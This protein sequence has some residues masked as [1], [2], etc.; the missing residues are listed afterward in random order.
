MFKPS[1]GY[2]TSMHLLDDDH[3]LFSFTL[4][5]WWRQ[6][7]ETKKWPQ[8][9]WRQE[10][11]KTGSTDNTKGNMHHSQV[12]CSTNFLSD[13]FNCIF[14]CISCQAIKLIALVR[15][16]VLFKS[17]CIASCQ[18]NKRKRGMLHG[19]SIVMFLL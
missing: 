1:L 16:I 2:N 19:L 10:L 7:H 8:K 6:K 15:S 12:I 17:V 5:E 3:S 18:T 9:K 13:S 11:W 14:T 4:K